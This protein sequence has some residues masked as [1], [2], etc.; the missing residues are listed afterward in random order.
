MTRLLFGIFLGI[1]FLTTTALDMPTHSVASTKTSANTRR[2]LRA[3]EVNT[4][5]FLCDGQNHELE[6]GLR[7]A[8]LRK[9]VVWF[10]AYGWTNADIVFSLER[11]DAN[12][13][14][15]SIAKA[16]W[17]H[18]AEPTGVAGQVLTYDFAPDWIAIERDESLNLYYQ[19][20]PMNDDSKN[21]KAH[22]IVF[23]YSLP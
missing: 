10:G 3:T 5:P 16:G 19:C 8:R 1:A 17:D 23:L 22:L 14:L 7:D 9:I 20:N 15:Q 12:K 4:R 18:Y 2:A 6:T 11:I 13:N 21:K